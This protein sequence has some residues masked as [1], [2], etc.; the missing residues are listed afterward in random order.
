MLALVTV[1]VMLLGAVAPY[2]DRLALGRIADTGTVTG[3]LYAISTAGSLVGT[4]ASALL[5]IPLIGTHRTFLVF[6]LALA[7]VAAPWVESRRWLLVP[8]AVGALLF[9]QPPAIG[10]GVPGARVV[11]SARRHTSTRVCCSSRAAN[12]G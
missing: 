1:P 5:L 2:A 7:L 3:R 4:F 6:A 10:A 11:F 9:V 12:A 8:V